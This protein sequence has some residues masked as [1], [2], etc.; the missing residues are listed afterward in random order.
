[1]FPG[2]IPEDL[3]MYSELVTKIARIESMLDAASAAAAAEAGKACQDP[4]SFDPFVLERHLAESRA[5]R[6][7][8]VELRQVEMREVG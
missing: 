1:M 2:P 3:T 6:L 5:Y 7:C 4:L 8:L